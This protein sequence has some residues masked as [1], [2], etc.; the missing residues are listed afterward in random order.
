M[1]SIVNNSNNRLLNIL[2]HDEYQK[3]KSNPFARIVTNSG[4][5]VCVFSNFVCISN[6][7][8]DKVYP[9]IINLFFFLL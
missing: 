5:A 6:F 8:P 9:K 1:R 3:V 4:V 2:I 7:K